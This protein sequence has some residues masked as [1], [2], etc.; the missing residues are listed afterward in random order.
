MECY[1]YRHHLKSMTTTIS[2]SSNK[3]NYQRQKPRVRNR[4]A[5]HTGCSTSGM[6]TR[7][8]HQT[9]TLIP[10]SKPKHNSKT[11]LNRQVGHAEKPGLEIYRVIKAIYINRNCRPKNNGAQIIQF[12]ILKNIWRKNTNNCY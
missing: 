3:V 11:C 10:N 6:T 2:A 7:H 8:Q 12:E 9:R 5:I 4:L 1:Q